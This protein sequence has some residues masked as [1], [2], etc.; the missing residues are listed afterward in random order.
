MILSQDTTLQLR[1]SASDARRWEDPSPE[2]Y[3][4]RTAFMCLVKEFALHVPGVS[5]TILSPS[6]DFLY[7]ARTPSIPALASTPST[8]THSTPTMPLP[9]GVPSVKIP[10]SP[11][12]VGEDLLA[13]LISDPPAHDSSEDT[14]E[15]DPQP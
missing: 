2:G 10:P 6:G 4:V 15:S 5:V 14:G 3:R 12:P 1:L 9:G 13:T 7:R 8:P 11:R